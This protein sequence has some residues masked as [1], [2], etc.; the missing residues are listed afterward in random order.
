MIVAREFLYG[1]FTNRI[2]M[3]ATLLYLHD[4]RR[5]MRLTSR[6]GGNHDRLCMVSK[7]PDRTISG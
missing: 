3:Y 6:P 4:K 1:R 2:L 7:S 5:M